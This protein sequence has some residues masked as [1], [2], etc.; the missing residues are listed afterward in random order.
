MDFNPELRKRW[1]RLTKKLLEL[2]KDV[3]LHLRQATR[4]GL[5]KN[6]HYQSYLD[7]DE[8]KGKNKSK[9]RARKELTAAETHRQKLQETCTHLQFRRHGNTHGS[10]A[11]CLTCKARWVGAGWKLDGSCSK[12]S[13]PLPSFST[14]MDGSIPSPPSCSQNIYH[15]RVPRQKRNAHQR[16]SP[17]RPRDTSQSCKVVSSDRDHLP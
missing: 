16:R 14:T 2:A 9:S 5:I 1:K 6:A 15:C 12:S 10:F 17:C 4:L 13:L 11:T 3:P 8:V 7:D